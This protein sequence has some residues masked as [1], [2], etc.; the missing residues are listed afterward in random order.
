MI[1]FLKNWKT[2][3]LGIVPLIFSLLVGLGIVDVN[4]SEV[5][6]A[7]ENVFDTAIAFISAIVGLIGLFSKDGDQ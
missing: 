1:K 6:V 2:T 5:T 7:T 4:P 3:V